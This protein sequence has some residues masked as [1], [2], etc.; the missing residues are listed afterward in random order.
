M[1]S[2]IRNKLFHHEVQPPAKVWDRIAASLDEGISGSLS[3]KLYHFEDQPSP[4]IWNK[5][6]GKLDRPQEQAKILPF[7][8][9]YRRPLKYSGAVAIFVFAAIMVSLLVSKKTES[10]LRDNGLV[11]HKP[12]EVR[13]ENASIS[14]PAQTIQSNK[15][16]EEQVKNN[17]QASVTG[18][19][20][21]RPHFRTRAIEYTSAFDFLP[22]LASQ[23]FARSPIPVPDEKYMTYDNGDGIAVRMPKKIFSA[24]ACPLDDYNCKERLKQLQEKFASAATTA[25]FN[26]ILEIL[27]NL[28]ENQ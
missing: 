3:D 1:S 19:R 6:A 27:K 14:S 12:K 10:E 11:Q 15:Q 5:I 21:S 8:I 20:N 16:V 13:K 23:N 2:Q 17:N 9:R 7:H 18:I 28:Q 25:D 4:A 26:G 24:I 22:R